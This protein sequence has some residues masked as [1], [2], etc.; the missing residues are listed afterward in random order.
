MT[1]KILD[2]NGINFLTFTIVDWIDL[3]TRSVY[4]DI[5]IDSLKYCQKEKELKVH[6]FVIMPSHIH[7]ILSTQN[8]KGLSAIIKDFKSFTS[9]QFL[10]Y[11]KDINQSESRRKWLLRQFTFH[12]NMDNRKNQHKIWQTNNHPIDLYTPKV[13]RQK[14]GYIHN[15]PVTAKIV[16]QAEDYI[17]SS[18]V[19]Y[20][21]GE[22]VLDVDIL[23][24]IYNDVGF[25][26]VGRVK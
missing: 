10:K 3:F 12:A 14:L 17:Y 13:V 18:A 1:R 9:K 20:V 25:V 16:R 26:N 7:L 15:N 2:Q 8:S 24:V 23:D 21:G 5:V 19:N 6:A 11:I 4:C 22:G